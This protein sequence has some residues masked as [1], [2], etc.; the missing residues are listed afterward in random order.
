MDTEAVYMNSLSQSFWVRF[1]VLAIITFLK[2][3]YHQYQPSHF[4]DQNNY[5]MI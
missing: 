3:I 4:S 5:T 2:K 1:I